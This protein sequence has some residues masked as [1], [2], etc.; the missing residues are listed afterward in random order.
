MLRKII[1]KIIGDPNEKELKRIQPI[2][3]RVNHFEEEYQ[4]LSEEEIKG[5]TTEFK[6]R[7]KKGESFD[8]ILP[9]AFAAVK[10]AC[11]RIYGQTFSVRGHEK[12]WDMIP[13]DVQIIGAVVLHEGRIAE[14]KTGE[15]KTLVCT[16]SLYLNALTEKGAY[17][18]TVNDYLAQRDAEWMRPVYEYLGLTVGINIHGLDREAKKAA[19]NADITYGTNN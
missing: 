16:M 8:D 9:E 13:Y 1:S 12:K 19:Y 5:K 14:M 10:N 18:V 17:L 2:V 4:K 11:R 15:G 6:E 3:E 7:L